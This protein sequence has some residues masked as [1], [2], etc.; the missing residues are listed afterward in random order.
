MT[1]GFRKG[2]DR[3]MTLC[4]TLKN[5]RNRALLSQEDFAK[6]LA[7][8]VATINRWEN[9][10]AKPN[11]AAMKKIKAFCESKGISFEEIEAAWLKERA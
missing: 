2:N 11:I 3:K 8:S 10:K 9:G 7:V 5:T 4:E 1:T 6:E